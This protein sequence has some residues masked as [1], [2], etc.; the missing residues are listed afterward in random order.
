M[1]AMTG[2]TGGVYTHKTELWKVRGIGAIKGNGGG[3]LDTSKTSSEDRLQ[4]RQSLVK[5]R[6]L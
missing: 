1:Y 3:L 2:T 5:S 6:P 4:R